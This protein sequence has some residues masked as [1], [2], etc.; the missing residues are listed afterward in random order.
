VEYFY[1]RMAAWPPYVDCRLVSSRRLIYL[2]RLAP[3]KQ[4]ARETKYANAGIR[5]RARP[6][7]RRVGARH[8]R[9]Y[10]NNMPRRLGCQPNGGAYRV[11]REYY[12]KYKFI[13]TTKST[14]SFIKII[15]N[16]KFIHQNTINQV[17][18]VN[19]DGVSKIDMLVRV[20]DI[21][22]LLY[23]TSQR[24]HSPPPH[25]LSR[26]TVTRTSLLPAVDTSKRVYCF[27][28]SRLIHL[29]GFLG[30]RSSCRTRSSCLLRVLPLLVYLLSFPPLL[31]LASML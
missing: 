29:V 30:T 5:H 1:G 12:K 22:S 9:C 28:F 6:K 18:E 19:F 16:Y 31:P 21:R 11:T 2:Y 27:K 10:V 3:E 4:Q 26:P 14:S 8:A 25:I 24:P 17:E 20:D 23:G 7:Q 13:H 15:Q